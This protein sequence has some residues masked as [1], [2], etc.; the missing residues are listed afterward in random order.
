MFSSET[1]AGRCERLGRR[2]VTLGPFHHRRQFVCV[3]SRHSLVGTTP[4]SE[5]GES[6]CRHLGRQ[7]VGGSVASSTK[8][9]YE[10][11]R[12]S[13][14]KFRRLKG[15]PEFLE[16]NYSDSHKAWA[17]I[18]FA[19]WCCAS[20]RNLANTI[21]GK[22]TAVQYFHRLHVGVEL[23]VTAPVVQ[24]GLK[25][26]ARRRERCVMSHYRCHSVCS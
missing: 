3:S 17:L 20:E 11:G 12:R 14:R 23:P 4:G 8:R 26:I 24:C 1:R 2:C 22:F 7:Y 21:A 6:L 15:G 18:E 19:L 9:T 13:C 25:G 10:S 5:G 16:S